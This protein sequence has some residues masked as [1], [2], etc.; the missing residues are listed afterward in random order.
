MPSRCPAAMI[1]S[2]MSVKFCDVLHRIAAIRQVAPHHVIHD[3]EP[4]VAQMRLVLGRQAADVHLDGQ[5][6]D[7]ELF[8]ASGLSVIDQHPLSRFLSNLAAPVC[9]SAKA[10]E[11]IFISWARRTAR[12]VL[13]YRTKSPAQPSAVVT[14]APIS[15]AG[16]HTRQKGKDSGIVGFDQC[17]GQMIR[18]TCYAP[19]KRKLASFSM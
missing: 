2:S 10:E 3:E 6:C 17:S 1:L 16:A 9:T 14:P 13:F 12:V 5:F 4:R 18:H 15:A 7:G 19:A 8:F 11:R